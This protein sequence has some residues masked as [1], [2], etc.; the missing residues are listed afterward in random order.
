MDLSVKPVKPDTVLARKQADGYGLFNPQ[1]GRFYVANDIAFQVWESC[2][3]A[4]SIQDIA[5]YVYKTAA[6]PPDLCVVQKDVM[7][8]VEQMVRDGLLLLHDSEG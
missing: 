3:G 2:T 7:E 4:N 6:D 8:V 1:T 5:T